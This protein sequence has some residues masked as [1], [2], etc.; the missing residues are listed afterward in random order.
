M[1]HSL[2]IEER[3]RQELPPLRPEFKSE[4]RSQLFRKAQHTLRPEEEK[5]SFLSSL[6]TPMKRSSLAYAAGLTFA[7]VAISVFVHNPL[8]PEEV[9][10]KAL[11]SYSQAKGIYHE[12]VAYSAYRENRLLESK[13]EE[14]YI[15]DSG[16]LL[17]LEKDPKSDSV[18]SVYLSRSLNSFGDLRLYST[19]MEPLSFDK[20]TEHWQ[21]VFEGEKYYCA[22]KIDISNEFGADSGAAVLT[23]APEDPSVYSLTAA[24]DP[25][26]D[27]EFKDSIDEIAY[28]NYKLFME[29]ESHW[30]S[31][32]M[33]IQNLA[34]QKAYEYSALKEG[35]KTF[36]LFKMSSPSL[37]QEN[38]QFWFYI[39]AQDY[40][41]ARHEIRFSN[42]PEY[43]ERYEILESEFLP[44][45]DGISLFDPEKYNFSHEGQFSPIHPSQ[46]NFPTSGCF[47]YSDGQVKKLGSKILQSLP[48]GAKIAWEELEKEM[49]KDILS[50]Q[51]G[52]N[53]D[54]STQ[55][56]FDP[57]KI[58][59]PSRANLLMGYDENNTSWIFAAGEGGDDSVYA[60]WDGV[61]IE[62]HE[63][64]PKEEG[65]EGE[66]IISHM[67][68]GLEATAHYHHGLKDIK[69]KVGQKVSRGEEIASMD[70]S[71]S[72]PTDRPRLAFQMKMGGY[73]VDPALLWAPKGAF[74]SAFQLA[75][76]KQA[77]LGP[78]QVDFAGSSSYSNPEYNFSLQFPRSWAGYLVS[79]QKLDLGIYGPSVSFGFG[80]PS[81]KEIFVVSIHS[82]AQWAQLQAEEGPKPAYLG[83]SKD[84]VF[85]YSG[86]QY[87]AN[88]EM[89]DRLREVPS[90]LQTFSLE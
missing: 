5:A 58:S 23:F 24:M 2:S 66:I 81:Q 14:T 51:S 37:G 19:K 56:P 28:G 49:R 65:N 18:L 87:A 15:D 10:A 12:K 71:G 76:E 38:Q 9:L 52:D 36:H 39:D 48:E 13:V 32:S 3:L 30:D 50:N 89:E 16:N 85:G 6:F 34:S 31:A 26:K 77:E 78:P 74:L 86:A 40:K 55:L 79:S 82:K 25:K 41:L 22:Q 84:H 62:A 57:K 80:L 45:S 8:R 7:A 17:G 75:Q 60:A 44:V 54:E 11:E 68:H 47:S 70:Y 21:K 73:P 20:D 90:I 27:F 33:Q 88:E 1:K 29:S 83:E 69:L 59:M 64:S 43:F 46:I 4:L 53:F 72:F 63:K 61:V 42:V 35:S 67:I